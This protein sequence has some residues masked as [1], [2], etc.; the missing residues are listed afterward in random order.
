ML[1]CGVWIRAMIYRVCVSHRAPDTAQ[2]RETYLRDNL[3]PC[4]DLNSREP[5]THGMADIIV[6]SILEPKG[7]QAQSVLQRLLILQRDRLEE[8]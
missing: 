7:Q 4:V 5:A 2:A 3:E 6:L 8:A 1:V